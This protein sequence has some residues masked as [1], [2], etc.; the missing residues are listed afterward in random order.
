MSN[1]KKHSATE[2]ES[3]LLVLVLAV[4]AMPIL[5]IFLLSQNNEEDK[6]WGIFFALA[7]I[8]VWIPIAFNMLFG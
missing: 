5:A 6:D 7:S 1:N 8:L 3:A 2:S 4:I